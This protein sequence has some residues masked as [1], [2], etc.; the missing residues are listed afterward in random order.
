LLQAA[1]GL[2]GSMPAPADPEC[3]GDVGCKPCC[4][5][6]RDGSYAANLTIVASC[7][8]KSAMTVG[9][10]FADVSSEQYITWAGS[11]CPEKSKAGIYLFRDDSAPPEEG[12]DGKSP[13]MAT[14]W[15]P[16]KCK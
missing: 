16:R 7:G 1:L 11:Y 8:Q 2:R 10:V 12:E 6:F 14:L 15:G 4:A 9:S 3:Q 13:I 5:D